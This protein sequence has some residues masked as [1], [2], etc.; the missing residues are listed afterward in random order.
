[1][2]TYTRV[3]Y[4]KSNGFESW[5]P[6]YNDGTTCYMTDKMNKAT[7]ENKPIINQ[8]KVERFRETCKLLGWTILKEE[9]TN[10]GELGPSAVAA[11]AI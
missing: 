1:M 7:G 2:K 3:H 4:K 5:M 9:Q 10:S 11:G 8:G 6:V